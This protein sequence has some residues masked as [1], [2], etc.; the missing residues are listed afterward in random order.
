MSNLYTF[1]PQKA[2]KLNIPDDEPIYRI[3]GKG[4]FD[5]ATL[6]AEYDELGKPTLIA[7]DG[8]PNFNLV[9]MNEKALKIVEEW[10]L[11][12]KEGAEEAKKSTEYGMRQGIATHEIDVRNYMM[13]I[14]DSGRFS[15]E[16]VNPPVLSNNAVKPQARVI[17]QEQVS[18]PDIKSVSAKKR[19]QRD[20]VNG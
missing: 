7:Y 18:T 10:I 16:R 8:A 9:P 19:D 2:A 12:M 3:S 1:P 6:L 15:S 13:K 14:S 17:S 4:F 20:L 11:R 5:G